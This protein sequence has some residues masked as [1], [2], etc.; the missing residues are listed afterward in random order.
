MSE[1]S[2]SARLAIIARKIEDAQGVIAE[3]DEYIK[4]LK[5]KLAE[6]LGEGEAQVGDPV[7][8]YHNVT[9]YQHKAFNAAYA[10]KNLPKEA[11]ARAT[12]MKPV[13]DSASAKAVEYDE[14]GNVVKG[15]TEDEYKLAQKPSENGLSVKIE[16][17]NTD[18]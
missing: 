6:E 12:V 1:L 11:I 9:V 14:D 15:L 7:N 13:F 4:N 18:D 17:I 5:A 3:Q 16:R 2:Q 8:G 10:R